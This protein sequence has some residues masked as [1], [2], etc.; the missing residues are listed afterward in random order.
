MNK[1]MRMVLVGL[2]VL[3]FATGTAF[4]TPT[5]QFEGTATILGN[6]YNVSVLFDPTGSNSFNE[7][8][9]TITFASLADATAAGDALVTKFGSG[10]DWNPF[11]AGTDGGRIAFDVVGSNYDYVTICGVQEACDP[12]V[13]Q[14]P[15]SNDVNDGNGF[16]FIQFS[17]VR[18]VPEPLTLSLFGAGLMGAAA[19]RRRKHKAA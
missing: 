8:S 6:T 4:A 5:T 12:T 17:P 16:T 3:A 10:F 18:D 19:A 14:G 11:D 1:L 7:L 15:F 9:P 13:V 2:S